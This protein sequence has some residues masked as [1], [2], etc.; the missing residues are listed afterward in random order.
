MPDMAKIAR[1]PLR[2]SVTRNSCRG[3]I[4]CDSDSRLSSAMPCHFQ[5][6]HFS[7]APKS[8]HL[9]LTKAPPRSKFTM[10]GAVHLRPRTLLLFAISGAAA[11]LSRKFSGPRKGIKTPLPPQN[12]HPSSFL[13]QHLSTRTFDH[14]QPS[15]PWPFRLATDDQR[16]LE[17]TQPTQPTRPSPT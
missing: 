9:V 11:P 13:P 12:S 2:S 17:P 5:N 3:Q 1:R 6:A 15:S 8:I 14:R 16:P 4:V 10:G 7:L